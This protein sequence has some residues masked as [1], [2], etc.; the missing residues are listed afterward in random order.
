MPEIIL[1][2]KGFFK[3]YNKS[4]T[5]QQKNRHLI[6]DPDLISCFNS[7]HENY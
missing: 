7:F 6:D 4:K 3:K 2:N 1:L 5:V